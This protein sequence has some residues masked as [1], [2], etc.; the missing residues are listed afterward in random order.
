[1][2]QVVSARHDGFAETGESVR[3]PECGN[4]APGPGRSAGVTG[5]GGT[6]E[7][8]DA[9]PGCPA[10]LFGA[11]LL[12]AIAFWLLVL[13]GATEH[14]ALHPHGVTYGGT[15][16]TGTDAAGGGAVPVTV[17]VSLSVLIA[18]FISLT[19]SVLVSRAEPAGGAR[20][21]LDSS[22]PAAAPLIEWAGSRFPVRL[23]RNP[24]PG[25]AQPGPRSAQRTRTPAGRFTTSRAPALPVHGFTGSGFTGSRRPGT[26]PR[27]FPRPN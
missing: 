5:K 24:F 15:A 3:V 10:V 25:K 17:P 27:S 14:D 7:F 11:A 6:G 12:V 13:V 2:R 8:L 19:G 1:M 16:H 23:L 18:R 20:T 26:S 22:V 4:V 9:A 21:P